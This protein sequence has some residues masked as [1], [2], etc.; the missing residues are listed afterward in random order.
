MLTWPHA[1]GDWQDLPRV[2][3]PFRALAKAISLR[4]SVLINCYDANHLHH[5]ERCLRETG[6]RIEHCRLHVTPSNDSW[7]RDHG[8]IS[9]EESGHPK[10][11]DFTFNGWG[12]HRH[13]L[14]NIITEKL[15]NTGALG[16][17]PYA[18][19][20][21]V[22]EGGSIESDGEGTLLT[23]TQCLRHPNRNPTM[24]REDIESLLRT[25]LGIDRILWLDHGQVTGDDT[26][27]HIDMLARFCDPHTIAYHSCPDPDD[28]DFASLQAMTAQ[29]ETFRDPFGEPYRLVRLPAP[30]LHRDDGGHR[31]PASYANFL[32]INGAVLVPQYG[33]PSDSAALDTVADRFPG[34]E[35]VGIDCLPLI[36][37]GGSLHCVTMQLPHGILTP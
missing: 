10:I 8:P 35:V 20:A 24:S 18:R 2:E 29:L 9:V 19:V 13:N 32:I 12:K 11:L 23:T 1:Y 33:D 27:G 22:L 30:G 34:R 3:A 21:M 4:Q 14:D 25:E 5:V 28:A 17:T 7:T 16:T 15:Y 31:L 37:Q 26:D 36:E 6:A